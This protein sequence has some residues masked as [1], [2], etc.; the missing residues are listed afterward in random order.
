MQCVGERKEKEHILQAG[1]KLSLP[2][3]RN[4]D[5]ADSTIVQSAVIPQDSGTQI[6][7]SSGVV[8]SKMEFYG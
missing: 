8:V 4:Q 6:Q 1:K 2:D 7:K 5:I 3:G